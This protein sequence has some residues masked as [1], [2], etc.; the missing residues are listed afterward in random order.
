[1]NTRTH[2]VYGISLSDLTRTQNNTTVKNTTEARHSDKT[3]LMTSKGS[4]KL[5]HPLVGTEK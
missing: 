2:S 4:N 1:M 5:S 3:P